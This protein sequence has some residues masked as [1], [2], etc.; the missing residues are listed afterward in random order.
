LEIEISKI[1]AKGKFSV[2]DI[3]RYREKVKIAEREKKDEEQ[4]CIQI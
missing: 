2:S 3:E 1:D 4:K